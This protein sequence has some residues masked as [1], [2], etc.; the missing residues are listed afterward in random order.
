MENA[1]CYLSTMADSVKKKPIAVPVRSHI[2]SS[3]KNDHEGRF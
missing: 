2:P 3:M 1:E